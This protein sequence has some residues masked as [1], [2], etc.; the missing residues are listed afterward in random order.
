MDK[1]LE[2]ITDKMGTRLRAD[3]FTLTIFFRLFIPEMF[4]EYDKC[5]YLDSDIVVP[6]DISKLYNVDLEFLKKYCISPSNCL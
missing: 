4:K 2:C 1:R 6:G 3:F 5:I